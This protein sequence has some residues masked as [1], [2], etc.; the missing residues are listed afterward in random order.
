MDTVRAVEAALRPVVSPRNGQATLGTLIRD[1][2]SQSAVWELALVDK[3][4]NPGS[5]LPLV[6][7]MDQ[8]WVGQRSRHGGGDSSRDQ[9]QEEAEAAVHLGVLLVQWATQGVLRKKVPSSGSAI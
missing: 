6:D 9:F 8:L 5:C 7:M 1:L 2:R 4:G 3:A